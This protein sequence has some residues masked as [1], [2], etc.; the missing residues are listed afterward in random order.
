MIKAI[1]F[2][3][4]GV[5][6]TDG[7]LPFKKEHFGHD[8]QLLDKATEL[9]SLANSRLMSYQEFL[10]RIAQL[11]G[12]SPERVRAIVESSVANQELLDYIKSL[13]PKY[14]IGMLSNASRNLL[15]ELFSKSQVNLFDEIALSYETGIPK[16]DSRAYIEAAQ[17]LGLKPSQCVFIDDQEKHIAGARQVGM[18]AILYKDFAQMKSELVEILST[19]P[20]N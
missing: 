6:T 12:L 2:D 4:F 1:I 5:L 9:N 3:C 16:P 14:K 17:D 13:K 7:W 8:K 19:V 20:D 10:S 11:A 15:G 18:K